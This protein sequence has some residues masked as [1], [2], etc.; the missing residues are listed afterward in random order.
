MATGTAVDEV[1]RAA[2]QYTGLPGY[3]GELRGRVAF[4][5]RVMDAFYEEDERIVGRAADLYHRN[6][7][8]G[9]SRHLVV[10]DGDWVVAGTRR[11]V[12]LYESG[13]APRQCAP[14][15]SPRRRSRLGCRRSGETVLRRQDDVH[16][17]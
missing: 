11:P 5:W 3:A 10:R 14:G 7:I 12:V 8:R 2:W 1:R 15:G 6:D 13:F 16:I 17:L 4:A 9:T